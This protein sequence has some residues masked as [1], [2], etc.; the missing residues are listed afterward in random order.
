[1]TN[2]DIYEKYMPL[3]IEL[4]QQCGENTDLMVE[5]IGTLVYIAC[6]KWDQILSE[7]QF[8][9]F[10]QNIFISGAEDDLILETIMLVAT[11]VRNEK[12]AELVAG[13]NLIPILHDLLGAKQED[14]E[15]V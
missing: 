11:V 13:S 10:I 9:D 5:L 8:L 3:Y 1:M 2:I 7:H 14:D 4:V 12:C 6:D 15:M